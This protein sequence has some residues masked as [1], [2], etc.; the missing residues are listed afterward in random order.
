M[1]RALDSTTQQ[2]IGT[3]LLR[4]GITHTDLSWTVWAPVASMAV[5][6]PLNYTGRLRR[7]SLSE[8]VCA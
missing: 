1:V 7:D 5:S 4:L 8:P 2:A 6:T 3:H